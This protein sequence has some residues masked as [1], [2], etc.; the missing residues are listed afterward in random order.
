MY[1]AWGRVTT[2]HRRFLL[3]AETAAVRR[4]W[5][6]VLSGEAT[7]DETGATGDETGATGDETGATG[8][9]TGATGDETRGV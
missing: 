2:V 4:R 6:E 5:V 1:F 8:D 9:E 7:E 3:A